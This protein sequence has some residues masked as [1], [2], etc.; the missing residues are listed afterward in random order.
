MQLNINLASQPY[1]A[2][3]QFR[4]MIG[5]VVG[6]LVVVTVLL[7][8]YILYQRVQSRSVNQQL[9]L[10]QQ[11]MDNL[12]RE[13]MQ[14]RILLAKPANR[15]VAD[16]SEFLN[17]LFARKALSWTRLF[18]E[19]EKIMPPDLRVVSI[20]QEYTKAGDLLLHMTVAT[21]ARE[22][23]VELVQHMEKSSHF[24][25]P[26]MV[27]ES[28]MTNTS[29]QSAGPGNN[30]IDVAAIYVPGAADEPSGEDKEKKGGEEP[31]PPAKAAAGRPAAGD[32]GMPA[33]QAQNQPPRPQR[34]N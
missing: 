31:A 22:R 6:V 23:A 13:E 14:A 3:R 1:E 26:Q 17:E 30:L 34:G 16:Q 19:M 15:E 11:E 33:A 24:R 2:A 4:R 21:D 18:T 32:G 10:V 29:D 20:K 8:G 27:N 5:S 9:A 7:L 25:Q 28:V 12:D